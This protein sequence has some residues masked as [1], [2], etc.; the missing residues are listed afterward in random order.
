M[1][2]SNKSPPEERKKNQKF[3]SDECEYKC[4]KKD[5]QEPYRRD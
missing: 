2:R 4:Y 1:L 5:T 3:Q